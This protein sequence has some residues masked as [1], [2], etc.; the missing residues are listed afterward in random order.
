MS[1]LLKELI[2][3]TAA[4][5][6]MGVVSAHSIAG[7]RTPLMNTKRRK[8]Q[9]KMK[10]PVGNVY[11]FK[12]VEGFNFKDYIINEAESSDFDSSDVISKLKQSAQQS[13]DSGENTT[14][15]ALE[16]ENG[17]MVKVWVPDDQADDFQSALEQ[18]L[19]GSDED[20]DDENNQQEIAEVLWNLRKDFDI[21]NVEWA[22]DLPQDEEQEVA[23]PA[24]EAGAA[25][26]EGQAGA[27]AGGEGERLDG[28]SEGT[29]GLEG[30]G[31]EMEAEPG[32]AEDLGGEES[33]AASAL[34]KVIDMMK[35][36]AEARK[37]EA[38][39]RA[40][41]AK[42]REAESAMNQAKEKVKQEEDV[43]D[44]E[45]YY[46]KQKEE[47]DE[48]DRLAKLAKY[49]HDM[50]ADRGE[51][52]TG[53]MGTPEQEPS[54]S[55]EPPM[56]EENEWAVRDYGRYGGTHISKADLGDL[57]LHALRRRT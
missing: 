11:S 36:D 3:E 16:D 29:E 33:E 1:M 56:P 12:F 53:A 50:A 5:G 9:K 32:E 49:K 55:E 37:A 39:A 43:L 27:E 10:G 35:A 51:G 20:K 7:V 42:A 41:E 24:P 54:M 2:K 19:S 8:K 34:T 47:K 18:A 28:E 14:A 23:T 4:G 30:K 40:A 57:V 44:M 21:V 45:A 48:S 26:A 17:E 46:D 52:P 13:E 31:N 6:A 38:D 15:F 25:G 22:A